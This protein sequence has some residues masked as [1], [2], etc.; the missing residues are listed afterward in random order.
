MPKS[1]PSGLNSGLKSQCTEP[2]SREKSGASQNW[3]AMWQISENIFVTTTFPKGQPM[4]HSCLVDRGESLSFGV[5]NFE[6]GTVPLR[7]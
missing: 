7:S 3:I 5:R 4:N 6:L 2:K 1:F